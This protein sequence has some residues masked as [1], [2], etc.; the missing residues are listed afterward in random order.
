MRVNTGAPIPRST[1]SVIM[2]EDTRLVSTMKNEQG[3]DVEE[4][5]IETLAQVALREN[6][7]QPGSDALKGEKV[8]EMGELITSCGGEIGTL[9]FV[10]R[11]EVRETHYGPNQSSCFNR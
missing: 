6:T 8:A 2:V 3:E 11:K 1:D 4:R 10:G 9:A 7:R 5:T